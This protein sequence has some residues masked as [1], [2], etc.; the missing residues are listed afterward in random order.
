ML[1]LHAGDVHVRRWRR[2]CVSEA[3]SPDVAS[4]TATVLLERITIALPARIVVLLGLVTF[5]TPASLVVFVAASVL[6]E[7]GAFAT[8]ARIVVLVVV[9]VAVLADG[10]RHFNAT[11]AINDGFWTLRP[12]RVSARIVTRLATKSS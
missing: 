10:E 6:L 3:P 2:S 1:D 12:T 8:Q 11:V 5:A 9:A 4:L 7:L